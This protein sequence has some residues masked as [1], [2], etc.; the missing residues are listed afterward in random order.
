MRVEP[1][2]AWESPDGEAWWFEA[3]H[4]P[5]PI[6]HLFA[7]ILNEVCEGWVTGAQRWGIQRPRALWAHVNG[8]LFYGQRGETPG[9]EE[10][11]ARARA[12]RW[13]V[14]E[15]DT[16]FNDERPAVVAEN[17]RLQ[18]IDVATL[19]DAALRSHVR[20][21]LHHLLD[22]GRLHFA[23]QGRNVVKSCLR[24]QAESEGVD[25]ALIDAA[26]AGGSPASRRP[27]E[28]V[29]VIGAALREAGVDAATVSD[30]DDVRAVPAAGIALNEYLDEFGHRLLD[31]YDLAGRTLGERPEV[32]VASIRA[33]ATPRPHQ[34]PRSLP[35]MSPALRQL[36]DEARV[37]YGIEDD[38][39]GVCLFW[40]SGLLRRGLLELGGRLGLPEEGQVFELRAAELEAVLDGGAVPEAVASRAALRAAAAS[41]KPPAQL[42]GDAPKPTA[43]SAPSDGVLRGRG[44]GADVVRGPARV[45]RG[46][47]DALDRVTPGD[48]LIAVTT[49]PGYNAVLPIVAAVATEATMDH[50]IICARE[51]GIPAVVG[52]AG[53]LDAIPDGA[54]VEVD[55]A[56]GV[57][58]LVASV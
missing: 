14:A 25:A 32:V 20:E 18:A 52:V 15:A 35:E 4:F 27:A 39:D 55:A 8:Y 57:V 26:L 54:E 48:I 47:D 44:V 1:E 49:N 17:R 7:D 19:D 36:L 6:S 28:M 11:E 12:E 42:G 46:M 58:R 50:T 51:L 34:H 24:E 3:A 53:L 2:V 43:G 23:H 16:W 22:V 9:D 56:A 5:E 13:W 38:D 10:L 37:S 41:S 33:T 40:P 30:L 29:A 45:V 31:S 21:A